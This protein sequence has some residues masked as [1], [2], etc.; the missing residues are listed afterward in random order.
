MDF[1]GLVDVLEEQVVNAGKIPMSGKC[2]MDRDELLDLIKELRERVPEDIKQ[3]NWIREERQKILADA[4]KEAN[5]ILKE[6]ES[7]FQSMVD[8]SE[9]VKKA[10]IRANEIIESAR[11]KSKEMRIST[12]DY[13]DSL[14]GSLENSLADKLN[15]IREDR[16]SLKN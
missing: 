4:K 7:R 9:I 6:A 5:N 10:N 13:I 8:E 2:M 15:V 11:Q 12:H 16:K 3:A 14:L 1:L